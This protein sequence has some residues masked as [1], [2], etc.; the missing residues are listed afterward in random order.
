VSA[1]RRPNLFIVGAMK[2]GTTFFTQLLGGHP[3][4]FVSSPKEPCYFG[5]P[6]QLRSVWPFGWQQGLWRSEQA[7]LQLFS[8]AGD[9][10][11][12]GEASTTYSAS[13]IIADVAPRIHQ[14]APDARILY[15]MRDP[16]ERTISHYWHMVSHLNEY[17]PPLT[18]IQDDPYYMAVSHY[19]R[20]L[21]PYL[22][23]FGANR[24]YALTFEQLVASP[25]ETIQ[26]VYAW[27]GVDA[28][29]VPTDVN[30]PVNVT[31]A[32]VVQYRGSIMKLTQSALWRRV[33][34]YRPE[35]LRKFLAKLATK[36][37]HPQKTSMDK[38]I[39]YLR[40]IQAAQTEELR[41]LL[42]RDFPEWITLGLRPAAPAS[43]L[44]RLRPLASG[45]G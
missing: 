2:S 16:I 40:P 31:P 29:F 26:A 21:T 28:A 32:A 15:I 1:A 19:A 4:I 25:V 30:V 41:S 38:V 24:V 37:V 6:E 20:Q 3:Q 27:L 11:F 34:S 44:G 8:G 12:A 39:Q 9:A 33:R 45:P 36:T 5:D 43:T 42:N 17:R 35:P 23:Y 13:P 7:Y 14:F 10:V 22:H 18:A